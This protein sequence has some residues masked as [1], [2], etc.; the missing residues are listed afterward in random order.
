MNT[1]DVKQG[2]FQSG[3]GGI[4]VAL[5]LLGLT[6]NLKTAS[7]SSGQWK[8]LYDSD[9]F[10]TTADTNVTKTGKLPLAENKAGLSRPRFE[11]VHLVF[12]LGGTGTDYSELDRLGINKAKFAL[13]ISLY[14]YIPFSRTDPGFYL[15]S[16]ANIDL[17][18]AEALTFKTLL[19]YQTGF[20]MLVGIG[21]SRTSYASRG[22][23]DADGDINVNVNQTQGLL[24]LGL[25]LSPQ[26]IDLL[27]TVPLASRLKTVFEEVEYSVRPAGIQVSLLLSLR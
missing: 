17:L 25:N 16:G 21:A 13:P 20:N 12:G 19:L 26:R 24:A 23:M 27:L 2:Y 7:A 11:T 1:Q 3:L 9:S 22:G 14:A 18:D 15:L 10:I 8:S 4:I 6:G 5:L